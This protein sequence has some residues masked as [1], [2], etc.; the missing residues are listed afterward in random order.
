MKNL[1]SRQELNESK[2]QSR[3]ANDKE[4]AE[5]IERLKD[6]RKHIPAFSGFG[7]PNHRAIDAQLDV[8]E[9]RLDT[10]DCYDRWDI[11]GSEVDDWG[12]EDEDK[13]LS[14]ADRY[15]LDQAVQA[16][17]WLANVNNEEPAA[18]DDVWLSK[19]NPDPEEIA[20]KINL[21]TKEWPGKCHQIADMCIK[22]GVVDGKLRYGQFL[23]EISKDSKL[24]GGKAGAASHHGWVELPDKRIW[25]PTRWAFENKKPYIYIGKNDGDY[26]M[27]GNKLKAKY[28]DLA[29]APAYKKTDRMLKLELDSKTKDYVNKIFGDS[30]DERP[31][32]Q[33]HWLAIQDP[34]KLGDMAKP[35]YQALDKLKLKV[36]IPIDNWDYKSNFIS[37]SVNSFTD[38]TTTLSCPTMSPSPPDPY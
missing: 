38:D 29:N 2:K 31:L 26:D 8:L 4:I 11:G 34:D 18:A 23:G 5:M 7:D 17:E 1:K 28:T 13:E 25:D 10:D 21:P 24:F 14:Q 35:I 30:H 22:A 32:E 12:D 9:Q 15:V 3:P 19:N 16:A 33:V 36:L 6:M 27:G 20:K 37:A